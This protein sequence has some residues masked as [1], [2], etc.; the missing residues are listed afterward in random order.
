MNGAIEEKLAIGVPRFFVVVVFLWWLGY[1]RE[2]FVLGGKNIQLL[3][4]CH[5][6]EI[7]GNLMTVVNVVSLKLW[8]IA[9]TL[10]WIM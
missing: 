2:K 9:L 1:Y 4:S 3:V 8:G 5:W 10:G 6:H 7:E